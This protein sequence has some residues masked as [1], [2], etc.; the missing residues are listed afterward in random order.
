ML[1]GCPGSL[2]S[3]QSSLQ[4]VAFGHRLLPQIGHN[5]MAIRGISLPLLRSAIQRKQ[6]H[7]PNRRSG[8]AALSFGFIFLVLRARPAERG[9]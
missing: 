2:L 8:G 6:G 7:C 3:V 4:S 5:C 1:P 9:R